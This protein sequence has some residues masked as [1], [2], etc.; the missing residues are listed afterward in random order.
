MPRAAGWIRRNAL[1]CW[2]CGL[3]ALGLLRA[4]M[5]F[6]RDSAPDLQLWLWFA[7]SLMLA[8]IGIAMLLR[9]Q[10]RRRIIDSATVPNP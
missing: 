2:L 3:A 1:A 10:R 5:K 8:G 6:A 4:W 9:D 7:G